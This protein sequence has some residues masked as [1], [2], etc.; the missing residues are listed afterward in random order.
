[1][2]MRTSGLLTFAIVACGAIANAPIAKATDLPAPAPVYTKA[3]VMANPA[4]DWSGFY[5]GGHLGYIWGK[6]RVDDNGVLTEAGAPT[7]GAVGGFLA[8]HNWQSGPLVLGVEGDIGWSDATGHGT[9]SPPSPPPLPREPNAYHLRWDSHIV[10]KLGYA[11]DRWLVFVSGGAAIA[12]FSFQEGIVPPAPLAPRISA[13][14]VG[15]SVGAGAE[16]AF[17]QN[18]LGR[19]QYIYDDFGSKSYTGL[20]GGI[21]RVKLSGQTVRSALSWKF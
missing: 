19:L 6:S 17:T 7:N 21:Y 13:T 9:I 16:Y 5:I 3:P 15:F 18:L 1:M 10:G 20:D 8:G 11:A 14:Y 12:G 2:D 4:Y